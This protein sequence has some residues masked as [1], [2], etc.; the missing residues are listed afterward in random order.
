M[1]YI[2][3]L[4]FISF[5]GLL[6]ACGSLTHAEIGTIWTFNFSSF[7]YLFNVFKAEALLFSRVRKKIEN[8]PSFL[9]RVNKIDKKRSKIII[10]G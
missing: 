5:P 9:L 2:S 3:L 7:P 8:F 1:F 10:F 6:Q 4:I